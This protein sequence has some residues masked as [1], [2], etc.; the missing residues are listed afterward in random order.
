MMD[1]L[2]KR[3]VDYIEQPLKEGNESDLKYIF[4]KENSHLP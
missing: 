3:E 1:W 2:S 4:E